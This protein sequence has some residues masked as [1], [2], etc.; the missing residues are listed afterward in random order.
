MLPLA[1]VQLKPV[2]FPGIGAIK[3]STI[4]SIQSFQELMGPEKLS[5]VYLKIF[6]SSLDFLNFIINRQKGCKKAFSDTV[7]LFQNSFSSELTFIWQFRF[8][9][10]SLVR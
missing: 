5:K 9:Q 8:L 10:N 4:W 3:I 7:P 1:D 6:L 2:G